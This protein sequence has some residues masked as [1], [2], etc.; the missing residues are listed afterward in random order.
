[1]IRAG[2]PNTP[3]RHI[4]GGNA[5]NE[6]IGPSTSSVHLV[7]P[8]DPSNRAITPA[9]C[10]N[11]AFAFKDLAE[12]RS[13]ALNETEGYLYSRNSNP[14]T[15][16]F[17][18]K[19]AALEGAESATSFATG[20]AAISTTLLALLR[21][22]QRAVT[23]RDAYGATFLLFSQILPEFGVNCQVCNTDDS[24]E[25]EAAISQGCDL[26]Y[27]ES[28]TNPA[29]KVLD[30]K[31]LI[32]AAHK[33]GAV[34]VV[35]NTFATPINQ[36]PI[37]LGADL[38]VHSATKFLGGHGDVMGG[39]LCG[40]KELVE[41][42]YRFRELT[43][44]SLDP[45]SAYLLLR[46]LKTLG[47][48]IQRHNENALALARY[49]EKHPKVERVHYPGL[50]SHPGHQIA[51]DQM[52]GFGGV[53]SF[54]LKGGMTSVERFL[55]RLQY[56]YLAPNLGQVDTVAGPTAL[57]SH[58]ELSPEEIAASGVPEGLIR[59]SVGIEDLEDL[60]KDIDNALA[61]A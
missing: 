40:R 22:P 29:I 48:R 37:S 21:A 36:R 26:L 43:G 45:N 13:V 44:P 51:K 31:R 4:F 28:P 32:A 19:I 60:T 30:L 53:L 3:G 14:T 49:L 20:M 50:E 61:D 38:V 56:A 16:Q 54:E 52:S 2:Q 18:N 33:V 10:Q 35:D 7:N 11:S 58:L 39:V 42:V 24:E 59:Y 17:E 9:I 46:S 34:T 57:T 15:T 12:W 5:M 41:K 23:V 55:P 8:I 47:L 25:I 1:M 27:L 6:K